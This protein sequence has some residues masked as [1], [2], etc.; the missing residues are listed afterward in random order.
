MET[1]TRTNAGNAKATRDVAE[2][3]EVARLRSGTTHQQDSDM[4]SEEL[5]RVQVDGMQHANR[6]AMLKYEIINMT[7][8][9]AE[10]TKIARGFAEELKIVHLRS[11]TTRQRECGKMSKDWHKH[12]W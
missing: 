6:K 8:A 4:L 12:M 1:F 3:A 2:E 11:V 7:R 5:V 9:N 10:S